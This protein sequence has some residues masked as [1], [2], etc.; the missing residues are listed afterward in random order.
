MGNKGKTKARQ[1]AVY[2]T[3]NV[4]E[5]RALTVHYDPQ[6]DQLEIEGAEP[7]STRTERSY[8][9][10]SG[11]PKVV[12]SVPSEGK[13]AFTAKDALFA[14]DWVVAVDTNTKTLFGKRC[15]VCVS[16]FTRTPPA[17]CERSAGVPF[18]CLA[19]YLMVGM[20]DGINPEQIGWHLTM[21]RNLGAP[22]PSSH[23]VAF[24]VDSEL[25]SHSAINSRKSG[26][27]RHHL[28]PPQLTISYSSSDVDN[29]TLGGLMIR[30]CDQMAS[31]CFTEIEKVGALPPT[32]Q[33]GSEDFEALYWSARHFLNQYL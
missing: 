28:L 24:V 4:G 30:M 31:T 20:R 21:T 16:Y 14:Y 25:G 9:R 2:G 7:G 26:Y 8:A 15:G 3:V 1:D 22:I 11:K 12:A 18:I 29:E 23:R 6:T 27:Y 33:P 13:S 19:A 10:D 5:N 32:Y 17:S